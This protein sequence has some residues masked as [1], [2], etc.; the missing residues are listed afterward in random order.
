MAQL[1]VRPTGD[2]KVAG[3]TPPSPGWQHSFMEICSWNIFYGHF[4]PSADSRRAVVSFW[5]KNL[6]N[7]GGW[8]GEAK[9]SCSFCHWGVDWYWLT[10]GQGLLSLQQ[11][12]VEGEWCYFFC[13]FIVFHFPLSALALSFFSS[14]I[15]FLPFS[16]RRH[17]MSHKGWLVK[18]Q[19][20]LVN[21]LED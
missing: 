17:K 16:G 7:T 3:S 21:R 14:S 6:H 8:F 5:R 13:S 2:Q 20:I 15:S 9:V 19:C 12:R 4:L 18:P 1:D 10:V 11:A